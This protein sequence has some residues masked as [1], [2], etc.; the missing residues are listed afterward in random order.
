[1]ESSNDLSLVMVS[2]VLTAVALVV[3]GAILSVLFAPVGHLL[4]GLGIRLRLAGYTRR[5]RAVDEYIGLG[6]LPE[7][8]TVLEKSL[9]LGAARGSPEALE[10]VLQH[11]L[12]VLARVVLIAERR[13]AQLRHLPLVEGLIQARHE[14]MVTLDQLRSSRALIGES[15]T[16]SS[17]DESYGRLV[18]RLAANRQGLS[19]QFGELLAE[20]TPGESD[21]DRVII[22]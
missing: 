10:A 17:I 14:L 2:L 22:H 12:G 18:E 6:A 11:N 7:A 21:K 4:H 13:N 15:V 8:C 19:A 3:T 9:F 1:M 16:Q 20:L 5:L